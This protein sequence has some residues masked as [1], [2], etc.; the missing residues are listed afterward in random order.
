M[1]VQSSSNVLYLRREKAS[2]NDGT[3]EAFFGAEAPGTFWGEWI[4]WVR[5][6]KGPELPLGSAL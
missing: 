3:R 6:E 2:T 1:W 5:G 4:E